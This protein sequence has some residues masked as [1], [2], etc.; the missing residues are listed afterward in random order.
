MIVMSE[1]HYK[2]TSYING[3][4]SPYTKNSKN[5]DKERCLKQTV[6][7]SLVLTGLAIVSLP[8]K[9]IINEIFIKLEANDDIDTEE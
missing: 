6:M 4:R 8:I 9:Y 3:P 7:F 2:D 1:D 5:F